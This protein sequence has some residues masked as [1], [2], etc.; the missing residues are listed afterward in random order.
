[1]CGGG[2]SPATIT[3]P[4]Y[5]AYDRQFEMQQAAINRMTARKEGSVMRMQQRLNES[6]T[7]K[8]DALSA[9]AA[10]KRTLAENTS[11]QAM[12]MAALIGTPPPEKSAS[13]PAV[14]GLRG[15]ETKKGKS[16]LRIGLD[17]ASRMSQGTGLNI[18]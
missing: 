16:A 4:D 17:S 2:G 3:Q 5:E 9:L 11:A 10:Q 15:V 1:M 12:R 8:Q 7:A 14:G 13:A 18:T 6:I